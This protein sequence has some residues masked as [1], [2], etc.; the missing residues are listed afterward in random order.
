MRFDVD[1]ALPMLR[2]TPAVLRVWLADLPEPWIVQT[3]GDGTW[4]AFDVVGHLI[5]GERTDWI[6]RVEH[7]LTHGEAVPFP[8]FDRFA[9]LEAS[10]GR[11]LVELLD[12]FEV[13][14]T[15]SLARLAELRLTPADLE[16]RGT[17]PEFGAVTLSQHL[18]TWVVHDLDHLMQTARAMAQLYK[19]AVGPWEKY[20]RI[21]N[22]RRA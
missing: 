9:Q 3:E 2:R 13:V 7:L 18:S 5:H 16:R 11:T 15:D 6:P 22:A 10:K 20:L 4:N 1:T 17:H 14:R 21:V 8:P 19:V 12:T